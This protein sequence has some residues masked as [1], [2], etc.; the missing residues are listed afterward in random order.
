MPR[1]IQSFRS[2]GTLHFDTCNP[3]H[4]VRVLFSHHVDILLLTYFFT[5]SVFA[6]QI[7]FMFPVKYNVEDHHIPYTN[8]A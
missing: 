7:Y 2:Q 3:S 6:L 8:R 1:E 5:F 4:F